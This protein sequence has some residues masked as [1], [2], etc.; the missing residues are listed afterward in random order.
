MIVPVKLVK[1]VEA[2]ARKQ[3]QASVSF[4]SGA[5]GEEAV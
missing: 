3:V 4:Y 1:P 2:V 5:F